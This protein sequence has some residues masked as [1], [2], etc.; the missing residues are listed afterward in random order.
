MASGHGGNKELRDRF[1]QTV[2]EF[3]ESDVRLA[4]SVQIMERIGVDPENFE[5]EKRY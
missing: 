1:M 5:D 4:T 2:Y 3:A